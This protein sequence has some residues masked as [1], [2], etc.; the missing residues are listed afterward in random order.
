MGIGVGIFVPSVPFLTGGGGAVRGY[1]SSVLGDGGTVVA[2]GNTTDLYSRLL[3]LG[4]INSASLV[5]SCNGGKADALYNFVPTPVQALDRFVVT[6]A[7][8]KLRIG[9]DGLYGSVANNVPAFEFNTDGT[10]RGLLVEPG[11]TN[12]ALR[13]QEFDDVYWTKTRTTVTQNASVSPDGAT[14]ADKLIPSTDNNTHFLSSSTIGFTSGTV[15]TLSVFAR[16]DGYDHLRVAFGSSAFPALGR[17]ASFN[18]SAGTVGQTQAGVTAR[19]QAVANG[20]YRCSITATASATASDN[21]IFGSQNADDATAVTF[22]GNGTSGALL[23]QAQLETGSVATSPIVTTAGT[24]SRVADSVTL[25]SASS[26]IGQSAGTLY[27]EYERANFTTTGNT[28]LFNVS[29][30]STAN[31]ILFLISPAGLQNMT[32]TTASSEQASIGTGASIF[33]M[34]RTAVAYAV[35]DIA[36]YRNGSSVGTDASATIPA[37]NRVNIGNGEN[38]AGAADNFNGWIR[39]AVLFPTRLAN[40]TLTA[41]TTL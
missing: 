26:L 39:S 33:G 17:G 20:F 8:T 19:I 16:A 1:Q 9:S 25:A 32:I 23:W 10:Y 38:G 15:Y 28:R 31:R 37:C 41:L 5:N 36:V 24:A 13:S 3:G 34:N 27:L 35:N 14:S 2:I 22:I 29:D 30:G 18:V 21:L 7:S 12:L 40:A 6:R 11:A 4:L